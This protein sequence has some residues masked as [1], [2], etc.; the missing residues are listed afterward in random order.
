MSLSSGRSATVTR[1]APFC[2]HV[3]EQPA[4][5]VGDQIGAQG[6][7][8]A[9]IPEHP[10]HVGHAGEHHAAIGHRLGEHQR[11]AVDG[12]VDIAEDAEMEAGGGD[13]DVG[14]ELLRRISA[15]CR[16]R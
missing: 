3:I 12:E 14:I 11:L 16:S 15:G 9:E 2:C 4:D 7:A 8:R 13:D 6:P 1:R 10:R 5:E